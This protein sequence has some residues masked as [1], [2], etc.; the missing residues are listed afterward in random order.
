MLLWSDW[1]PE[2]QRSGTFNGYSKQ[3]LVT[4]PPAR[5]HHMTTVVDAGNVV[6]G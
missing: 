5:M 1:T 2:D 4:V 3:G 6:V